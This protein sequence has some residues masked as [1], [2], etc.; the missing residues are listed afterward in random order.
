MTDWTT[1]NEARN[2]PTSARD[3]IAAIK[4]AGPVLALVLWTLVAW[5]LLS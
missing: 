3:S 5:V 4:G 1:F 2:S